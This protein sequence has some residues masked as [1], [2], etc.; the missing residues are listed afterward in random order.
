MSEYYIEHHGVKGM[1]WGVRRYQNY[2][3]TYTQ[4]GLARFNESN[5]R[6]NK[7]NSAYQAARSAYKANKSTG[8]KNTLRAARSARKGAKKELSDSYD[9]LK[10][11]N[12]ADKGKKLYKEGNT[13]TDLQ[14]GNRRRAIVGTLA[15][16][17]ASYVASRA[18]QKTAYG[19]LYPDL[20]KGAG[21]GAA[22]AV[23]G[24]VAVKN[25]TVNNKIKNM[26]AYYAH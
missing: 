1:K 20:V 6:Y 22:L 26:R 8:N 10:L 17:G 13:I 7:A 9:N 12:R 15:A 18:M 5:S 16:A 23:S 2:D 4:K 19:T 3:G 11:Q 24:A 25:M 14:E 21:A